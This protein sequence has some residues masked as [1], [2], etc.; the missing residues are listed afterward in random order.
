L[1]RLRLQRHT[2]E[3][4]RHDVGLPNERHRATRALRLLHLLRR[5]QVSMSRSKRVLIVGLLVAAPS[6]ALVIAACG[7]TGVACGKSQTTCNGEC[8]NVA[9]D[10]ANCGACGKTCQA[11]ELCG[12]G[13]CN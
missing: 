3:R 7:D 12:S 4:E 1:D 11:T 5:V 8:V 2:L 9:N 13:A 6:L 10:P